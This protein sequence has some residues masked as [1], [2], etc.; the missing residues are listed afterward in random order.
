MK[1]S[2]ESNLSID[3]IKFKKLV[4]AQLGFDFALIQKGEDP[5]QLR[6]EY[7]KRF[8]RADTKYTELS[9]MKFEEFD[10]YGQKKTQKTHQII[11]EMTELIKKKINSDDFLII[12]FDTIYEKDYEDSWYFSSSDE[13]R[14]VVFYLDSEK[15][16]ILITSITCVYEE[17]MLTLCSQYDSP[18]ILDL[19]VSLRDV[20]MKY[21]TILQTLG[22][23]FGHQ[24]IIKS[25]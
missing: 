7:N 16:K 25:L 19:P 6:S 21:G 14:F 17:A 15:I 4:G 24:T 5:V 18:I 10:Y 12:K 3:S 11:K 8:C 22:D 9:T 20:L 23:K 2:I 13:T 1:I